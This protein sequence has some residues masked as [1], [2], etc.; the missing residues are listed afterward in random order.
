MK[1]RL[2]RKYFDAGKDRRQEEK[3]ITGDEIAGWHHGLNGHEFKQALE[4][5]DGQ[6]GLAC[7]SPWG[8]K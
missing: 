1:S 8:C 3:G 5:C 6:G 2:I 4:D 7:C